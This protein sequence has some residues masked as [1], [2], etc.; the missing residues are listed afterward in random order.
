MRASPLRKR[1]FL[2]LEVV[3]GLNLFPINIFFKTAPSGVRG[4]SASGLRG[5][6]ESLRGG[7]PSP[8]LETPVSK[9][10]N[11][12]SKV[13]HPRL[14]F[15]SPQGPRVRIPNPSTQS[16]PLSEG[17]GILFGYTVPKEKC[18][19]RGRIKK[20]VEDSDRQ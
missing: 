19:G 9:G 15:S 6:C 3:L 13:F 2:F 18:R 16:R 14:V 12:T 11:G 5:V 20:R 4:T 17:P 10:V 1:E 8:R 7:I